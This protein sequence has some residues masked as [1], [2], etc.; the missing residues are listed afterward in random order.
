MN[1]DEENDVIE[2]EGEEEVN[3]YD[4]FLDAVLN[5]DFTVANTHL[6][7]LMGEKLSGALDAEMAR[8]S[9]SVYQGVEQDVEEL[10]AGDL[11]D[12][13]DEELELDDDDLAFIDSLEDEEAEEAA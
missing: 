1:P 12:L 10:D 11:E 9:N 13:S 6:N 7:D 4:N 8:V 2:T 3:V 5:Q